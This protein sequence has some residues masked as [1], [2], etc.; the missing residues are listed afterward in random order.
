AFLQHVCANDMD[1]PPGSAVY[2]PVLNERGT[3][4]SDITAQRLADDRYRL[5]TGAAAIRRDMAW[6]R[7]H[8]GNFDVRLADVTERIAVLGLM[9]PDAARIAAELGADMVNDLGFFRHGSAR[10]AG[11]PVRAARLSYVGE[12]GWEITCRSEDASAVYAAL[13]AA[14]AVPA[15]VYAQTSMRIEKGFAAMGHEL[16]SDVTP[17][18]AGMDRFCSRTKPYIGSDAIAGRR[19]TGRRTLATVLFDDPDAVPL[20]HEPVCWEGRI[21]GRTTSAAFGYRIGRPIALGHVEAGDFD[22]RR[23]E[24]DIAGT[25]HAARMQLA[26]AFDPAGERMRPGRG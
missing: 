24:I 16:D 2:T 9:G 7:R 17:V 14:G 10:I 11:C 1:R 22:G 6:L 21:V 13:T 15:G 5:F 3:Y 18:E 19:K 25:R 4:E 23:V 20:G 8:A 12:A 26:P